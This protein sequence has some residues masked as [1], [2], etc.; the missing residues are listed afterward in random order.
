MN[1]RGHLSADI[2]DGYR[3][4]SLPPDVLAETEA[5]LGSCSRCQAA[6]RELENDCRLFEDKILPR[7]ISNVV[8]RAQASS[9]PHRPFM[10]FW[11]VLPLAATA[12][13][14]FM[15]VVLVNRDVDESKSAK[16]PVEDSNVLVKGDPTL[17][18]YAKRGESVFPVKQGVSLRPKD[19]IRF[20]VEPAENRYLLI[21]SRD[22]TGKLTL[23]YPPGAVRSGTL[24]P[25]RN[26]L[27]GSIELDEAP[28]T[29]SLIAVFSDSSLMVK[30]VL[31]A[32]RRAG[33]RRPSADQ[34]T[35]ARSVV[36]F[37]YEKELP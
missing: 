20:V 24:R 12:A 32:V 36:V 4:G 33:E 17:H 29:E 37:E 28:G 34:I 27:P 6:F 5:H 8:E 3:L 19:R 11:W 2:L 26:E 30:D 16:Q 23:Y 21:V 22:A 7:T 14:L 31:E 35:G 15:V 1:D 25:G 13:A 10:R 18:V 9:G